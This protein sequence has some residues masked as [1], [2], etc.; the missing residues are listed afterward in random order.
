M[1]AGLLGPVQQRLRLQRHPRPVRRQHRG[2][3]PS[4]QP[5]VRFGLEANFSQ[6]ASP[7]IDQRDRRPAG[8]IAT[9]WLHK[10]PSSSPSERPLDRWSPATSGW[11]GSTTIPTGGAKTYAVV[12]PATSTARTSTL[13]GAKNWDPRLG[14]PRRG[15]GSWFARAEQNHGELSNLQHWRSFL[16][17]QATSPGPAWVPLRHLRKRSRRLHRLH[18]R[19]A[20]AHLISQASMLIEAG[21]GGRRGAMQ[22]TGCAGP[23]YDAA[24]EAARARGLVPTAI[25]WQEITFRP[26]STPACTI[27]PKVP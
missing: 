17:Q 12:T 22:Y 2:Q 11:L 14:G 9:G 6:L 3:G 18:D 24:R 16:L 15:A 5:C 21:S 8:P 23:P 27:Q 4:S 10:G 1:L 13:P 25:E 26:G 20:Q 7:P 19:R